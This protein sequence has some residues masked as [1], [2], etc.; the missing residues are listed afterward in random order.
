M[1]LL[2]LGYLVHSLGNRAMTHPT[3]IGLI[4]QLS[5][6]N[7]LQIYIYMTQLGTQLDHI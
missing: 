3:E 2:R 1:T 4:H 7:S 6:L 5:R